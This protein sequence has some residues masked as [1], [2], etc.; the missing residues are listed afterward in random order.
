MPFYRFPN[1]K[2]HS[3]LCSC[4][5]LIVFSI[6]SFCL[7][8][9]SFLRCTYAMYPRSFFWMDG[10]S[11]FCEICGPSFPEIR[12]FR[13][14]TFPQEELSYLVPPNTPTQPPRTWGTTRAINKGNLSESKREKRKK[15]PQLEFLRE[16]KRKKKKRREGK[17]KSAILQEVTLTCTSL[18]LSLSP[19][20][21]LN[22]VFPLE[23]S[24][25][26]TR[27]LH[28]WCVLVP[29]SI[30]RNPRAGCT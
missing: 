3:E 5:G 25:T 22:G 10:W 15:K 1:E 8:G 17:K 16:K 26:V 21:F 28:S 6:F 11:A 20:S 27:V 30:Q 13:Q 23:M 12:R 2:V 9:S 4:D 29:A 19:A 7:A 24:L 18:Y 14:T